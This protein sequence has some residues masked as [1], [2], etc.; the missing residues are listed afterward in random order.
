MSIFLNPLSGS[1]AVVPQEELGPAFETSLWAELWAALQS[2]P[3]PL[4]PQPLL[5][6]FFFSF[7]AFVAQ[8]ILTTLTGRGREEPS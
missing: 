8:G 2:L 7:F 5:Y 1:F 4:G 3:V 6:P